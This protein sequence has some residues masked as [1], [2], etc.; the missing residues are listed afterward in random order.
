[1]NMK[2]Y[3]RALTAF[4]LVALLP[5]TLMGGCSSENPYAGDIVICLDAGHGGTDSGAALGDRL[6]KNDNLA[7][8]LAV[9]DVLESAGAAVILTRSDDTFV[10]LSQRSDFAN[11]NNASVFVSFH[12]NAGGGNGAEVWIDAS[13]DS[14]EKSLAQRILD[15]LD[16]VG[17]S[18]NRGVRTGTSADAKKNY[19]VIKKTRMPACLIELGFIDS[20]T[21]NGLLEASF[22]AYANAIA[23]AIL[24]ETGLSK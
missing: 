19:T 15:G 16:T 24:T 20:D 18:K 4:L 22:D 2:R 5:A 17:V 8:A 11:K 7:M 21:D 6:E 14:W 9:R 12:R 23:Q 3:V 13:P 1:M 10:E